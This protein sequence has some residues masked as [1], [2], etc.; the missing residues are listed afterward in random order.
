MLEVA[1]YIVYFVIEVDKV[2]ILIVSKG[3]S[4]VFI[5]GI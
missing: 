1:Q 5:V 2:N 3:V 4:V